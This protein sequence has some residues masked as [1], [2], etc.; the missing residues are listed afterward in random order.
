MVTDQEPWSEKTAAWIRNAMAMEMPLFGVCYGHQLMA[1][2]L[3]GRVEYHPQGRES[4]AIPCGSPR[5][6]Q[7]TRCWKVCL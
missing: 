7:K 3:G 4:D 6:L 2:A 1:H 5:R